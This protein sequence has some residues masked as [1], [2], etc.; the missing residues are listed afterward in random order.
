MKICAWC[1]TEFMAY[2]STH[3]YCSRKCNEKGSYR[4][5][6]GFPDPWPCNWCGKL[7]NPMTHKRGK[8]MRFCSEFC[9]SKAPTLTGYNVTGEQVFGMLAAQGGRCA[10]GCGTVISLFAKRGEPE[11]AHIDH[12][13]RCCSGGARSCG[14]CVRGLLCV[15]CNQTLGWLETGMVDPVDRC[16][17]VAAY[18]LRSTNLL[19]EPQQAEFEKS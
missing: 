2:K 15:P 7:F 16:F 1:S 11:A 9:R 19:A 17:G 14:R 5:R 18:L 13:H 10:T 3:R 8:Q 4:E 6:V 12:D